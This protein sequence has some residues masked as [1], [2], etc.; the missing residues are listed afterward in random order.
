MIVVVE[1]VFF[2]PP[3]LLT[4]VR[5]YEV[6]HGAVR[7]AYTGGDWRGMGAEQSGGANA[8]G[9]SEM[10]AAAPTPPEWPKDRDNLALGASDVRTARHQHAPHSHTTHGRA[11]STQ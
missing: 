11:R 5:G 1:A 2:N 7:P 10:A 3:T 4:G 8:S 6:S 9:G